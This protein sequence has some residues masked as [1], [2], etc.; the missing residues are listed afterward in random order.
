MY[1][2]GQFSFS[3][4]ELTAGWLLCGHPDVDLTDFIVEARCQP[5]GF[6]WVCS[7]VI[8]FGHAH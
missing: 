6:G 1:L 3:G 8:S 2:C 7:A 4:A 5:Y